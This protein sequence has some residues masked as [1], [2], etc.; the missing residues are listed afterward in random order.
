MNKVEKKLYPK[1][2]VLPSILVFG[3]FFMIPLLASF[4]LAFTSWN[5]K[6]VLNPK[7]NG[8]DNFTTLLQNQYFLL[9]FKNTIIFAVVTTF[10]IILI[11]LFLALMLDSKVLGKSVI[12]TVFYLPAVISLVV[13]GIMFSSLLRMDGL[14]NS[15]LEVIGLGSLAKDWL[16]NPKTALG[17]TIVAQ[18]WKWSGFTMA[19]FLAGLQGIGKEYYEAAKIDGANAR[20]MLS[21]ITLPL[22]APAFT[23][24]ITMNAIGGLKVFEQVYVMTNGGPGFSSQV[25]GTYIYKSFGEGLLGRSTAMGLLQFITVGLFSVVLN[26]L[27]RKREA[28]L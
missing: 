16:G 20:Q 3:I 1:Y 26:W 9:A 10:F 7:F 24:A 25:L 4:I 22:L 6:D 11:G 19:I 27:L 15:F 18:I 13:V 2:F 17:T 28:Q 14:V 12:R 23:V 8:I 5:I 21:H